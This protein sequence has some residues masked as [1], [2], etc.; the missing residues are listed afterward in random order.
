MQFV[1][2][3]VL[4]QCTGPREGYEASG[5][6]GGAAGRGAAAWTASAVSC[7]EARIARH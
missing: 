7:A 1:K 4:V 5:I 2:R 3:P 6:G